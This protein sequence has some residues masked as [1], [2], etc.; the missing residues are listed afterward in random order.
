MFN[1]NNIE[2][3]CFL[4][5]WCTFIWKCQSWWGFFVFVFFR[6]N[7]KISTFLVVIHLFTFSIPPGVSLAIFIFLDYVFIHFILV[8][9][10]QSRL[11]ASFQ[12]CSSYWVAETTLSPL[13]IG[14]DHLC[15]QSNCIIIIFSF[16]GS[17]IWFNN[18]T[19]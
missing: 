7:K 17:V 14:T 9:K 12:M 13:I 4:K 6:S 3:S 1:L 11:P 2:V 10:W 5:V 19:R 8:L 16:A 15:Q 18:V